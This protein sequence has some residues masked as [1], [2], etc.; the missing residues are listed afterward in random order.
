MEWNYIQK[1]FGYCIQRTS[2]VIT[3]E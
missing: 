2:K 1:Y 3:K